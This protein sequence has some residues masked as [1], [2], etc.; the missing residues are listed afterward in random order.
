LSTP[1]STIRNLGPAVETACIDAG[2]PDAETLRS[3]GAHEAYRKLLTRGQRPHFIGYYALHMALQG[4]PWNDCKGAEKDDLRRQFD[5][6]KV[7]T[8][9]SQRSELDR[10]LNEIGVVEKR[11][12]PSSP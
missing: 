3:I 6:L 11:R 5:Q 12:A 10:F 2:I 7:E 9:A 4:R 8:Q 1:I